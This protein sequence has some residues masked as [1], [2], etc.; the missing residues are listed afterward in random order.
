[1]IS[2]SVLLAAIYIPLVSLLLVTLFRM[3]SVVQL[4]KE[5]NWTRSL[6]LVAGVIIILVVLLFEQVWYGIGR[7]FPNLYTQ[8]S[9]AALI[10]GTLKFGYIIALLVWTRAFFELTGDPPAWRCALGFAAIAFVAGAL[11]A[12]GTI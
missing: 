3:V 11:L 2:E 4:L 8:A 5:R 10:V 9:S 6:N 1:M 12:L 7:F